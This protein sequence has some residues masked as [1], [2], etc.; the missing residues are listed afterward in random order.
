[1]L[2]ILAAMI[3]GIDGVEIA[4]RALNVRDA[5]QSIVKMKPDVV[6]LDIRLNG[7][8]NGMDV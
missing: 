3:S 2:E 4:G 7:G 6:I 5:I 8:C 1:V